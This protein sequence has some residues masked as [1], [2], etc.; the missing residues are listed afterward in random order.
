MA[1]GID[2]KNKFGWHNFLRYSI[3]GYIFLLFFLISVFLL[4]GDVNTLLVSSPNLMGI[5]LPALFLMAGYPLGTIIYLLSDRLYTG[6]GG[7]DSRVHVKYIFSRTNS[8]L[9]HFEAKAIWDSVLLSER[10]SSFKDR[11]FFISTMA[12]THGTIM[13]AITVSIALS[14]IFPVL[15]ITTLPAPWVLFRFLVFQF[16]VLLVSLSAVYLRSYYL[17]YLDALDTCFIGQRRHVQN[18][19]KA[20]KDFLKAR[21][22]IPSNGVK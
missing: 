13:A 4:S 9:E 10:D 11:I 14:F 16:V 20:I 17:S 3:P 19:D 7:K 6:P 12:Q 5:L 18:I 2:D 22:Q 1:E 15:Y 8:K 21:E